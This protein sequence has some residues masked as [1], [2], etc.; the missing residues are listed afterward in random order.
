[1]EFRKRALRIFAKIGWPADVLKLK[2]QLE[3]TEKKQKEYVFD[4]WS[5]ENTKT[6]DETVAKEADIAVNFPY[7]TKVRAVLFGGHDSFQRDIQNMFP[8]LRIVTHTDHPDINT[9]RNADIIFIQPI[10]TN[11]SNYYIARDAAKD[12]HIP[13]YHLRFAGPKRCGLEMVEQIRKLEEN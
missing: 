2:K 6:N 1:M 7:E 11:H 13:L 9:Y 12:N 8:N 4:G 5:K 10:R 3:D